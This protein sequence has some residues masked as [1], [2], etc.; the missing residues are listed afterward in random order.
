VSCPFTAY[1][2]AGEASVAGDA[3]DTLL[4]TACSSPDTNP[5]TVPEKVGNVVPTL[6]VTGVATNVASFGEM[7]AWAEAVV[8]VSV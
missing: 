6:Q 3:N 7:F 4:D 8:L 1:L 5:V 2:P